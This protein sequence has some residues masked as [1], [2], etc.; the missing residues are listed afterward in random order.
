MKYFYF[1]LLDIFFIY[2]SD[3]ASF[4]SFLSEN[5]LNHPPPPAPQSTHFCLLVLAFPYTGAYNIHK[6][7][8][9]YFH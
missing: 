2:I 6:T 5:P 4:H 7:K 9:L 8:G 3:T 1:L